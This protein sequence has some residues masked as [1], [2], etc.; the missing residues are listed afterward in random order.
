MKN[1][2]TKI[3]IDKETTVAKEK[4]IPPIWNEKEELKNLKE[5]FDEIGRMIEEDDVEFKKEYVKAKKSRKAL[6]EKE[7]Y[8]EFRR[9]WAIKAGFINE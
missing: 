3:N 2:G 8:I 4:Y 6:T 9:N 5:S 1:F 7:Y